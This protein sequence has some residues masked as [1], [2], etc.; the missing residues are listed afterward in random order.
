MTLLTAR[1]VAGYW[2]G[3]GGPHLRAV[4]WVA[5][6]M[7]ESGLDTAALSPAGAISLWQIMPFNAAPWGFTVA[8]L[9]DPHVN[10]T[11]AVK[12]SGGG[13][14]CAAWDSCYLDIQASGRYSYLAWPE[15][16]SADYN[17][18]AAAAAEIGGSVTP[19]AGQPQPSSPGQGLAPALTRIAQIE[20]QVLPSIARTVTWEIMKVQRMYRM[21]WRP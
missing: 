4:E 16:G 19:L 3:A 8:D 14:N 9:W 12:M 18:M 2:E 10:A 13:V 21:G 11:V 5:I 17:N 15:H 6:A 7:G 1:Q 20:H